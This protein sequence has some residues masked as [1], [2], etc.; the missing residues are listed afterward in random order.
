LIARDQFNQKAWLQPNV[1]VRAVITSDEEHF[2]GVL[3]K[4]KN[5]EKEERFWSPKQRAMQLVC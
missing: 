2:D 1:D 3:A 5:D 4:D